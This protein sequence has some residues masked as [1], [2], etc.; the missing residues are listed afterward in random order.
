MICDGFKFAVLLANWRWSSGQE[1]LVAFAQRLPMS[2]MI[3]PAAM[4]RS[5]GRQ[6]PIPR[7]GQPV[8]CSA[9]V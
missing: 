3:S 7:A 8:W 6:Q 1:V 2:T 9:A 5:S 4:V